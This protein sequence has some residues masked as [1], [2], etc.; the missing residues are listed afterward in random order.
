MV[1]TKIIK[2]NFRDQPIIIIKE[3]NDIWFRGQFAA[4]VLGYT[5]SKKAIRNRVKENEKTSP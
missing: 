3:G 2:F 1:E 4:K 5:N